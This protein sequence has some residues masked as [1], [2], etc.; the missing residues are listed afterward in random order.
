M[1]DYEL[2]LMGHQVDLM[3]NPH[4]TQVA[5]LFRKVTF[6]GTTPAVS[7]RPSRLGLT[8]EQAMRLLALLDAFRQ[9]A[10]LPAPGPVSREFVP[11]KREQN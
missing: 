3:V 1:D 11:P 8:A 10:N 4:Q 9:S 5:I 2:D 7:S 6:Q